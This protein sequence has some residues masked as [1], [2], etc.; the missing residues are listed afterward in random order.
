[1]ARGPRS[2]GRGP[3]RITADRA[4]GYGLRGRLRSLRRRS[5]RGVA[6]G[7]HRRRVRGSSRSRSATLR[8]SLGNDRSL[9]DR[10]RGAVGRVRPC[11]GRRGGLPALRDSGPRH[12]GSPAER[13]R[14][15]GLR[16]RR[17]DVSRR[18][19]SRVRRAPATC[20]DPRRLPLRLRDVGGTR[21]SH[22]VCAGSRLDRIRR[23]AWGPSWG[24]V[25][26][27]WSRS[28]PVS[29]SSR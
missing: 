9:P 18:S 4:R 1:M 15:R 27:R 11:G 25:D 10:V 23:V 28:D 3:A 22:F 13:G 8:V 5:D 20:A 12:P 26:R 14:G 17:R 29:T 24:S 6:R 16:E 21:S 19:R 7:P 2:R